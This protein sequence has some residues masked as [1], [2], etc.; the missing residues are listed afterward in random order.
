M[1]TFQIVV[2]IPPPPNH[3][4]HYKW[5]REARG[6]VLM[7]HEKNLNKHPGF[8]ERKGW[9]PKNLGNSEKPE[10]ARKVILPQSP[11]KERNPTNILISARRYILNVWPPEH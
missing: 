9:E 1:G 11:Q 4:G 8:K 3:E 10:K 2:L 7:G 6:L 5:N